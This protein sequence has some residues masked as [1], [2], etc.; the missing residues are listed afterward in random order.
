MKLR[1]RVR[2][3]SVGAERRSAQTDTPGWRRDSGFT[4]NL[5]L[6]S[7]GEFL[8]FLNKITF[9]KSCPI[10]V[11][12][13]TCWW[14]GKSV[15]SPTGI[16]C[17]DLIAKTRDRDTSKRI[18]VVNK[19]IFTPLPETTDSVFWR[20]YAELKILFLHELAENLLFDG[21]RQLDPHKDERPESCTR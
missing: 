2:I 7:P 8:A 18:E 10:P 16:I 11:K 17:V 13:E 19:V 3:G 6:S 1:K 12:F 21:V 5:S 20:V 9:S 14:D 15:T 4:G